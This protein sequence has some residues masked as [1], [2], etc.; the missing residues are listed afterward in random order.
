MDSIEIIKKDLSDFSV[1]HATSP[2]DHKS[3]WIEI[4]H[5]GVSKSNAAS[6]LVKKLGLSRQNVISIGNDFNDQ[7]LL[8]W[9]GKGF[10]VDNAPARLRKIFKTVPSNNLC[11]VSEAAQKAGWLNR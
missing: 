2:L 11:G 1:I 7:D 5:K 10:V 8:A 4:F 9:S 6:W 3:S